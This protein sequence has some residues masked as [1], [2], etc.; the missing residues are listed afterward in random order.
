MN[1][2]THLKA[3][4]ALGMGVVLVLHDLALAM[5]HADRIV[6]LDKGKLA[7]NAAA[8]D[9]LSSKIIADV[10]GVNTQWTGRTGASA[11][12]MESQTNA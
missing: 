7:A 11:L 6:V 9:A 1:L 3:C 4:A 2:V 8:P 12:I 10:W 5:N